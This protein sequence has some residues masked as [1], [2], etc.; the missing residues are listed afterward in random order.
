MKR[1]GTWEAYKSHFDNIYCCGSRYD[2]TF[3]VNLAMII[4]KHSL[5]ISDHIGS[6]IF[7][8]AMANKSIKL[9]DQ[10]DL[11]GEYVHH[12][13]LAKKRSDNSARKLDVES[14]NHL[15]QTLLKNNCDLSILS[16]YFAKHLSERENK[17]QQKMLTYIADQTSRCFEK[18]FENR[19]YPLIE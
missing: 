19:M 17:I 15:R 13:R 6:Q 10:K 2:P 18:E 7:Y 14:S 3:L 8:S 1:V 9:L 11:A 5:I 12:D 16:R 4:R